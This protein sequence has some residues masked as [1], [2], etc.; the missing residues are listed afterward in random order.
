MTGGYKMHKIIELLELEIKRMKRVIVDL[1]EK[2]LY[3]R[4][5]YRACELRRFERILDLLAR[6]PV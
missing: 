4:E 2:K 3:D 1:H 5:S 6:E